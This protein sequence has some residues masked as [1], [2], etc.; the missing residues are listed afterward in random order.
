MGERSR[1]WCFTRNNW[2]DTAVED[3]LECR[4]IIYG[5]EIGDETSTPHLQGFV[6]FKNP[7][8]FSAVQTLMPGCHLERTRGTPDEA[9]EYCRKDG[10]YTERGTCPVT[11]E[12][13]GL[14]EK[15][16]W[17]NIL[18]A[19][20][21]GRTKD[22]PADIQLRYDNNIKRIRKDELMARELSDTSETHLWYVGPTGCGKSR[23]AREENP[24][25][26]LKMC[27]KW[28][29][30]YTDQQAVIIEDL[31]KEHNKL[32]HHLK[33]WGDRYPFLA[34]M[35]GGAMKIRPSK[36]I[37]TSNYRPEEI[38]TTKQD[39]EP[40]L[41]RFK[42]VSW[43]DQKQRTLWQSDRTVLVTRLINLDQ[44]E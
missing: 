25:A 9:A 42:V 21:E 34:E 7:K 39:L 12:A 19:A 17:E 15:R 14:A 35:K 23:K 8:T 26:Y 44:M 37:V 24:L 4:Y 6:S 36:I 11:Q 10:D 29:D 3:A 13:K 30:G 40:I 16:K 33:L 18:L 43:E 20:K 1:N 28:W 27:N 5:K 2:K 31:D 38:W 22:I 32:C 41:R